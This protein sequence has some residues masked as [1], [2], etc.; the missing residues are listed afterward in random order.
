MHAVRHND[1]LTYSET[2]SAVRAQH[3]GRL[4]VVPF[5]SRERIKGTLD[6]RIPQAIDNGLLE[7]RT[8]SAIDP[9]H[10]QVMLCG[11]PAM[12]KETT[13]LLCEQRGLSRNRR[14]TPGH[15]TIENYW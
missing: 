13:A 10:S 3:D 2:I 8:G 4:V 6:G 9:Q 5:V 1:E 14:R 12:V 7:E 11:N 15:I